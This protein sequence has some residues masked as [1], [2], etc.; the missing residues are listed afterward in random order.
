MNNKRL[1]ILQKI[2]L[3]KL[4]YQNNL[5]KNNELLQGYELLEKMYKCKID[6]TTLDIDF[7]RGRKR[8]K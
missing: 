3:F 1:L 8:I 2:E 7:K 6:R 5:I 4:M